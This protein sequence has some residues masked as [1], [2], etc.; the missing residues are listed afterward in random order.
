MINVG[1]RALLRRPSLLC[2]FTCTPED[3]YPSYGV[4]EDTG[5]SGDSGRIT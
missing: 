1:G 5:V 4:E 2:H 3:N